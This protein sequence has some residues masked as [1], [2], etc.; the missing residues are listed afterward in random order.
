MPRSQ[1]AGDRLR[2]TH[3]GRNRGGLCESGSSTGGMG[4]GPAGG[5]GEGIHLSAEGLPPIR[6]RD[7]DGGTQGLPAGATS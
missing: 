5:Q 1:E 4:S 7:W 2:R 3:H 6:C